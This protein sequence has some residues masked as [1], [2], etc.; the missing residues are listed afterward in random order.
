MVGSKGF[1]HIGRR[2]PFLSHPN[3]GI[4]P[5][6]ELVAT[7]R[8]QP[9]SVPS[10][11]IGFV[12][13]VLRISL[14]MPNAAD[15]GARDCALRLCLLLMPKPAPVGRGF[16]NARL[17]LWVQ[18]LSIYCMDCPTPSLVFRLVIDGLTCSFPRL[19]ASPHNALVYPTR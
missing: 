5:L 10:P 8:R 16:D 13:S 6:N 11:N 1:V 4:A 3:E 17:R 19:R 12:R 18:T 14:T 15:V 9:Q 7:L 2:L